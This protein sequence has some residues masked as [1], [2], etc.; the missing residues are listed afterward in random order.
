MADSVKSVYLPDQFF[1]G[2]SVQNGDLK[3]FF[4]R[5]GCI[6]CSV[7]FFTSLG[8]HGGIVGIFSNL[9]AGSFLVASRRLE[10]QSITIWDWF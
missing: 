1:A 9:F 2:D 5:S 3:V 4:S 8:R 10:T 6:F 7:G